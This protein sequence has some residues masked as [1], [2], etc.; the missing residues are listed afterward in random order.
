MPRWIVTVLA[1]LLVMLLIAGYEAYWVVGAV[2]FL[3]LIYVVAGYVQS[4]RRD[5]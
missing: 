3:Y 4:E 1:G 2:G 5:T